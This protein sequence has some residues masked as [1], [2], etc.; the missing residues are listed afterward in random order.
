M[1]EAFLNAGKV[2]NLPYE[3]KDEKRMS[4]G[5]DHMS[6][7]RK[8]I[9]YLFFITGLHADYHRLSDTA[10]K[11]LPQKMAK[12]ARIAFG[13]AWQLANRTERPVFSADE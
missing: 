9:P 7:G 5:S 4:G 3:F 11:I 12:V 13:C 10:D 6:F 8:E 2:V 1:Q